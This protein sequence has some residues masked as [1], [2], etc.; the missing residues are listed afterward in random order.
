MAKRV[1]FSFDYN[2]VQTFRANVVRNHDLTKETGTSGFFDASIWEDAE[3]HGANSVKNLINSSLEN[4]SITCV[5]IG[6]NTWNRRW[7][8]YEILKSYDRGNKLFGIHINGIRDKNNLT[9]RNGLNPFKYLGFYI[10]SDG[11]VNNYQEKI[12]ANWLIFNDL[13]PTKEIF[14][15]EFR[16]KGYALSEWVP[17]YDWVAGDGFNNFAQWV[18]NAK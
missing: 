14:N 12:N 1:F 15:E 7:V 6:S 17:C 8:K 13:K 4:T 11:V 18:E 3:L 5:L 10:N 2:D 9:Y 16:N